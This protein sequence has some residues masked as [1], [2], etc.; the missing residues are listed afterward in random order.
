MGTYTIKEVE[1][2]SGIQAHTLRIWE[3]RYNFI[4]PERTDTNIRYY[5]DEQ[6][7]YILNVAYLN[8]RGFKI[9]KLADLTHAQI[10]KE[11]EEKLESPEGEEIYIHSLHSSMI[12]FDELKFEKVFALATQK[13]GFVNLFN[14]VILPFLDNLGMLWRIGTINPA[15]EHFIS[16]L[17][18]KKIFASIDAIHPIANTPKK[19]C[20]LYLPEGEFHELP[21]L[22]SYYLLKRQHHQVIFMGTSLPL[23]DLK[24]AVEFVKPD[25][26]VTM[27]T[28]PMPDMTIDEYL[29]MI[30][31]SFSPCKLIVGGHQVKSSKIKHNA[32]IKLHSL[33]EMS[34]IVHTL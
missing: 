10:N 19:K 17:I 31:S 22:L 6:L 3:Q 18:R 5:T 11:I 32:L 20:I 1:T 26:L 29:E 13:L 24:K 2:L 30:Y 25:Y 33:N 15:Q 9:S 34:D 4:V 12:D 27:L 7:K 16:N 23:L 14:R 28:M 8:Q 21:L